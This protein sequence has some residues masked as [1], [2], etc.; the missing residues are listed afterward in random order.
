MPLSN[1]VL[2]ACF[3]SGVLCAR[4][5]NTVY[6]KVALSLR[7][8]QFK[9][10]QIGL[11]VVGAANAVLAHALQQQRDQLGACCV[12]WHIAQQVA[13]LSGGQNAVEPREK[14]RHRESQLIRCQV[15]GA[16]TGGVVVVVVVVVVAVLVATGSGGTVE[17][18]K[19]TKLVFQSS[20]LQYRKHFL[21]AKS[22]EGSERHRE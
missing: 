21:H 5:H 13:Q 18:Q 11:D 9:R 1:H 22:Q 8:E 17:I 20:A 2:C 3:F 10:T 4:S 6:R 14:R 12:R 7:A 16:L 15:H 19:E